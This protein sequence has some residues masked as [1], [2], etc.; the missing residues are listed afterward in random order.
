MFSNPLLKITTKKPTAK[1]IQTDNQETYF[2]ISDFTDA[3][4]GLWFN[5]FQIFNSLLIENNKNIESKSLT[6]A[7][8]QISLINKFLINI[9]LLRNNNGIIIELNN[10]KFIQ[11]TNKIYNLNFNINGK[12]QIL[13]K[14]IK[15]IILE[16]SKSN[17]KIFCAIA[18]T[19]FDFENVN[20][21][22]EGITFSLNT[23]NKS[24]PNS[25]FYIFCSNKYDDIKK[26][27]E[28]NILIINNLKTIHL[29]K[30]L[31]PLKYTNFHTDEKSI[32]KALSW[33][34]IYSNNL[35]VKKNDTYAILSGIPK[36]I[37]F[38]TKNIF[39]TLP[40]TTL[41]TGLYEKARKILMNISNFQCKDQSSQ[42]FGKIP[43]FID[44]TKKLTYFF[45]DSTPLFIRSIYEYFI[46]TNDYKFIV[47]I[48]ENIKSAI[49][50]AYISKKDNNNFIKQTINKNTDILPEDQKS[51]YIP[52]NGICVE[53]QALWYTALNSAAI[54]AKKI[55]SYKNKNNEIIKDTY[56]ELLNTS[57]KYKEE[58]QKIKESFNKNFI[59][60]K[61]PY[62]LNNLNKLNLSD[63]DLFFYPLQAIYYSSIP[64]IPPLID[65]NTGLNFIK[66]II[67]QFNIYETNIDS[68]DLYYKMASLFL[69]KSTNALCKYGLYDIAFNQVEY[70]KNLVIDNDILGTLNNNI[71]IQPKNKKQDL[72][73]FSNFSLPSEF[74]RSIYQDFLGVKMFIPGRKIYINPCIP[75]NFNNVNF[76]LRFGYKEKLSCNIRFSKKTSN[77]SHIE[78]KV[79]I[80]N[81]PVLVFLKINLGYEQKK[82][83]FKY[84]QIIL[85]L[86]L[87]NPDDL[88]RISF[89]SLNTNLIKLKDITTSGSGEICK[90]K[91]K[92]EFMKEAKSFKRIM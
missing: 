10:K 33:S 37:N 1:F 31:I 72:E 65:K 28:T 23:I 82:D 75:A 85:K 3:N 42:D 9:T 12:F 52:R 22:K 88:I 54:I 56:K 91:Y 76:N 74:S 18:S 21:L 26:I 2:I 20:Q 40:G 55:A 5:N 39:N 7:N 83:N 47:S 53:T 36:N 14:N 30:S 13:E 48:W 60:K 87:C 34:I 92:V 61:A 44:K 63:K 77:I 15:N 62:I 68:N 69:N 11:K 80:I 29:N 46:Y 51:F 73:N 89:D 8:I 59:T 64:G 67:K 4:D 41:I 27:I 6:P 49:N 78:I 43:D 86:K 58:S 45:A 70:F 32:N 66:Y 17:K 19:E 71:L 50:K 57:K 90:I 35:L 25:E 16:Y 81:K 38:N 24:A 79:S 84:K